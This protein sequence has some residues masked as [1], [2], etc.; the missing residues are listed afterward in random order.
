MWTSCASET[1]WLE[2]STKTEHERPSI[3]DAC[4]TYRAYKNSVEMK[5]SNDGDIPVGA[6]IMANGG[7]D[8]LGGFLDK[9]LDE[10]DVSRAITK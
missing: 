8:L 3:Q 7:L 1:P 10:K 9:K 2:R 6:K 5:R 4:S